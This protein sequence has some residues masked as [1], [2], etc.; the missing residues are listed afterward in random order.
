MRIAEA[1]KHLYEILQNCS[2]RAPKVSLSNGC[3]FSK[4]D[5]FGKL[6]LLVTQHL[7]F[8]LLNAQCV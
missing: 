5:I 7:L 8:E 6:D 2:Y 4:E 3:N 1:P